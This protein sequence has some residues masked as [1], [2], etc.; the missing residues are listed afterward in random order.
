VVSWTT[1]AE[2]IRDQRN[3]KRRQAKG[4][5]TSG[6]QEKRGSHLHWLHAGRAP[7]GPS[8]ALSRFWPGKGAAARRSQRCHK[9]GATDGGSSVDNDGRAM[10]PG[11]AISRSR[12]SDRIDFER[13]RVGIIHGGA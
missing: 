1:G 6:H 4:R 7:S 10:F 3:R 11:S 12:Y 2:Q 9:K 5:A 8:R 13:N